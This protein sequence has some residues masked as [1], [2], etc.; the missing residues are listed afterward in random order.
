MPDSKSITAKEV[1]ARIRVLREA[2]RDSQ[3]KLAQTLNV[4]RELISKMESG[5][6]YPS[7]LSLARLSELYGVTTDYILFGI[8]RNQN[9][10]SQ[11]D[12]VIEKLKMI[13]R[14]L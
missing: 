8:S 11:I 5:R 4:S 13:R 12:W 7:V 2:Q 6:Q 1:G 9:L 14:S 10:G 3:E